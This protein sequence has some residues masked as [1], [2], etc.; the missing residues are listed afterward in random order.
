MA[1][2]TTF[3]VVIN[4]YNYARYLERALASV[5]S[6]DYPLELMELIVVDDGSTDE[7]RAI[8]RRHAGHPRIRIRLQENA[9]QAAAIAGGVALAAHEYVC[10]LDSDD[11]FHA[12]KLRV[13]DEQIAALRAHGKELFLCHDLE[14]YDEERRAIHARSWFQHARL[15]GLSAMTLRQARLVYPFSVPAGQVYSRALLA[16]IVEGVPTA[17]WRTGADNPIAHAAL[18]RTGI[19][20]YIGQTL[21]QYRIHG[22]NRLVGFDAQ[23]RLTGRAQ[24][25][26]LFLRRR[27]KLL[28]FLERFLETLPLDPGE[29]QDRVAYVKR[30]AATLP[31]SAAFATAPPERLSFVVASD[32]R[33]ASLAATLEAIACQTHPDCE[34]IVA[35]RDVAASATFETFARA[36]PGLRWRLVTGA[37]SRD[38]AL[39]AGLKEA[40]G[41]FCSLITCGDLPDRD[42]A[43]RHLYMHRYLRA[44]MVSACDFRLIAGN[45]PAQEGGY[46]R[47]K[48]WPPRRRL[49]PFRRPPGGHWWAF[50]PRS[51]NVMR[52]TA[53]LELF[54]DY[55]LARGLPRGAPAEWLL[56]HYAAALGGCTQFAECLTSLCL[57]GGEDLGGMHA[58]DPGDARFLPRLPQPQSAAFFLG[59]LSA[60]MDAFR[61]H[62]GPHVGHFARWALALDSP[63]VKELQSALAALKLHPDVAALM[64]APTG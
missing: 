42:F 38:R 11:E 63:D 49:P 43:E 56:L 22:A 50:S 54:A 27:P 30:L 59:F 6:Q 51:G 28:W 1:A 29:R 61:A 45:H 3:S 31:V 19:V 33:D 64:S 8:L 25:Q 58:R 24:V 57:E 10:L 20:H 40:S 52:R 18:L 15:S 44:S 46:G 41:A 17:D 21:G 16:R 7:S 35:A 2:Q 14:I 37:S 5:F 34:V 23:N 39:L 47:R 53:M 9:G 32:G 55:A 48:L 12:D 13:L 26:H 36:H 62:Y 60:H 4:N